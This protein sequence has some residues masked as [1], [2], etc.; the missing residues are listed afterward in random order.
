MNPMNPTFS[1]LAVPLLMLFVLQGCSS[2]VDR[3]APTRENFKAALDNA[4]TQHGDICLAMFDW[5]MDLT[6]ADAGA[7][8]RLA[9]QLPAFEKLG[10]ASS[11]VV[12]VPK[13]AENPQGVVKRYTLTAEGLK[14]YKPHAY[15]SRDGVQHARDFCVAHIKPDQVISWKMDRHDP[16]HPLAIVSYSYRIESAPWLQDADAQRV[17]PMIA[18]VIRGAGG[19]LQLHQGFTLEEHGWVATAGPV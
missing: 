1:K 11:A 5:P 16:Q 6:P 2:S 3:D 7:G 12:A 14:Y 9:V 15:K 10:L 18:R 8:N 19:G 4:M 17:L 13:T